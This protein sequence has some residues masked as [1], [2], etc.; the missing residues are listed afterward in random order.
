MVILT[1]F[2]YK[3][4]FDLLEVIFDYMQEVNLLLAA[5]CLD[6]YMFPSSAYLDASIS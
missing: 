4:A 5:R 6:L 2:Y 3:K 1:G